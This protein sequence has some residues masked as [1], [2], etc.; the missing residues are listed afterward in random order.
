MPPVSSRT[1]TISKPRAEISA[2][3]GE[4]ASRP[5]WICAGRKLQNSWKCLRSGSKAPRSGCSLGGR[6]SHFGPP[7]E[8]NK[9]ASASS[10]ARRVLSG[11]GQPWLSIAIPPTSCSSRLKRMPCFCSIASNTLW[12][13]AITSGPIPSPGNTAIL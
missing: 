10:Q 12:A 1:T 13:C 7:T 2:R 6:C 3:R 5:W 8:P 11:S 4:K 9:T